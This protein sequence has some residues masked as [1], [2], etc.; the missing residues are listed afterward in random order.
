VVTGTNVTV[1]YTLGDQLGSTSLLTDASGTVMGAQGYYPFGGTRYKTGSL[2]PTGSP[3]TDRLYTGQQ[4]IS[5]LGLYN[6]KARFYDPALGRF[7]SPDNITPGGPEG[8]NRYSYSNNSPINFNDPTGHECVRWD[9]NTCTKHDDDLNG[10]PSYPTWNPSLL[11]QQD[12]PSIC[13]RKKPPYT[14]P[15]IPDDVVAKI[16]DAVTDLVKTT[17]DLN[18]IAIAKGLDTIIPSPGEAFFT[19]LYV[20]G[21]KDSSLDI[22]PVEKMTRDGAVALEYTVTDL[23]S[24]GVGVTT[25]TT[26]AAF[27]FETGPIDVAVAG[28][29][30]LAGSV[31]TTVILNKGWDKFNDITLFP[32][33]HYLFG[34]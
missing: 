10:N 23:I 34:P 13:T 11:N 5:G 15:R 4:E 2:N 7:I 12:A 25:G 30:Y 1:Y 26:A 8:L 16:G 6:Y 28:A 17:S 21:Y 33:L 9:G 27:G 20:Q 14:W 19:G 24:T 18:K 3:I 22:S 31:G 29:G 32:A